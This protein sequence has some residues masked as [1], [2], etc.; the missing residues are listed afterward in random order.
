MT[1]PDGDSWTLRDTTVKA[2]LR[3]ATTI[4]GTIYIAGDRVIKKSTDG[5]TTWTDT[6]TNSGGNELF[7]GLA[8]NGEGLIAAGFN[9]QIWAMPVSR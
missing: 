1:S 8:S 4:H 2:S 7:M 9:H 5:G 3:A 6:Y